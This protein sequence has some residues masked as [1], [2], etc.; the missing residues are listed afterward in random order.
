MKK[1]T[2]RMVALPCACV[3]WVKVEVDETLSHSEIVNAAIEQ[4][5]RYGAEKVDII[6]NFNTIHGD[7]VDILVHE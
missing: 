2:Q 4:Y 6:P 7:W 3:A 1:K 5:Y